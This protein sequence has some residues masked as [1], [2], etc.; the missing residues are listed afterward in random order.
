[1]ERRTDVELVHDAHAVVGEGPAWDERT[2]TLLWV[3]ILSSRIHRFDPDSGPAEPLVAP[4]HVGAVVPRRG[5]GIVVAAQNGFWL[6]DDGASSG[7]DLRH[8]VAVEEADA[9]TRFNDG[10]CDPRGRLWAGTKEYAGAPGRGS[11]YRL[12][13]D[14]TVTRQVA[15]IAISNG[16]AWS[17]DGATMYYIDS[18]TYQVDAF[19]FALAE[20][21]IARRR[22]VL[23]FDP[24]G[25][26]PDGMTID[27]DGG[28]WVAFFGGGCV[29][30]F[31][32]VTGES[33]I[34]VDLPVS[35]VT[36]CA[37]GG[38]DLDDLYITSSN[39]DLDDA[40]HRREPTA[41][42]LFRIRPGVRGTP[43]DLFAG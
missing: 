13:P 6:G 18:M 4:V 42:G 38:P 2:G 33:T 23:T 11:L 36:S 40:G 21:T 8:W 24:A 19:D 28:L 37:F 34:Q 43:T 30:R 25:G 41:G 20:G 17:R 1:M 7:R 10:K 39:R 12:D 9:E 15:D 35:N 27:A 22:P 16:L 32:P 26:L 29:R 14:G 31:D 5:G 3:D